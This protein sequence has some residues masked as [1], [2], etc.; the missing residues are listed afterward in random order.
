MGQP[1][2]RWRTN[3]ILRMIEQET[4]LTLQEHDDDDDDDDCVS[5][6]VIQHSTRMRHIILSSV[7]CPA[8]PRFSTLSH[9]RHDLKKLNI[10]SLQL[11]S[12]TFLIPRRKEGEITINIRINYL[13]MTIERISVFILFADGTSVLETDDNYRESKSCLITF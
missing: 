13:P 11:L 1:K 2:K 7:A 4:R 10:K 8:V 3:F 5:T 12:E 6:L 9:K